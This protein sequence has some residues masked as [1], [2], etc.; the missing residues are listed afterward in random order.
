MD[1]E[2]CDVSTWIATA[3]R[4][5]G[6]HAENVSDYVDDLV[7]TNAGARSARIADEPILDRFVY[8]NPQ[9]DRV[10]PVEETTTR[11]S[12][13]SAGRRPPR[14]AGRQ[15]CP[16]PGVPAELPARTH[17]GQA[18]KLA[19][20]DAAGL[21]E[22]RGAAGGRSSR[23]SEL[24][25][26]RMSTEGRWSG[27]RWAG[28]SPRADRRPGGGTGALPV[29]AW[30]RRGP[31]ATRCCA[32]PGSTRSSSTAA[33]EPTSVPLS[34]SSRPARSASPCILRCPY[35]DLRT[36]T[37]QAA[38]RGRHAAAHREGR[39]AAV[40]DRHFGL[41][42]PAYRD[43]TRRPTTPARTASRS[44]STW[45]TSSTTVPGRLPDE[46]RGQPD[47][48]GGRPGRPSPCATASTGPCMMSRSA[49]AG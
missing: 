21:A 17:A 24:A 48:L 9:P 10:A 42:R 47:A 3:A 34:S 28:A 26:D 2:A 1:K 22:Q 33:A 40:P 5:L 41:Y 4:K 7:R 19:V 12:T 11:R 36:R 6:H 43:M 16:R 25:F 29:Q 37:P 23:P 44:R 45:M 46:P 8:E 39:P 30:R 35:V 38:D 15:L 13:S 20:V 14:R 27:S 32:A 49:S 31:T 18:D